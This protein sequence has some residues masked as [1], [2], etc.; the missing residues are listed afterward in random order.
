MQL[1]S[2][3]ILRSLRFEVTRV[4]LTTQK[5]IKRITYR[6]RGHGLL[7]KLKKLFLNDGNFNDEI[8]PKKIRNIYG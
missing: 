3:N 2:K 5:N 7:F 8:L 6:F 1:W 4:K